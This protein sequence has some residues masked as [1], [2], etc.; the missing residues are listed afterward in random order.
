MF[1]EHLLFPWTEEEVEM[2]HHEVC[3]PEQLVETLGEELM[4]G[5][6]QC[7]KGDNNAN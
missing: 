3:Q 2:T 6:L 4:V 5:W 7:F 1:P